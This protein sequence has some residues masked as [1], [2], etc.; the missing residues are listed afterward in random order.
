MPR[1]G[2]LNICCHI[3]APRRAGFAVRGSSATCIEP[4]S[5]DRGAA[6]AG[7]RTGS[8]RAAG[9]QCR[10]AHRANTVD[11]TRAVAS[12][13]G[14]RTVTIVAGNDIGV[15][16]SNIIGDQGTTLVA[17]SD[18]KIE[19]VTETRNTSGSNQISRSGVFSSDAAVT[20][21]KQEEQSSIR[22]SSTSAAGSTVGS[23]SGNV[24]IVAG[25][26][27]S[28]V[29]SD[30]IAAT[31]DVNILAKDVRITE[32][33]ETS[34]THTE[35]RYRQSGISVGVSSPLLDAGMAAR[36]LAE[37]SGKTESS[38]MQALGVAAGAGT[39]HNGKNA[40]EAANAR[41]ADAGSSSPM[42]GKLTVTAGGS[43]SE[44]TSDQSANTAKG[45]NVHAGGDVN[46]MALGGGADSNI[47]IQGSNVSAGKNVNLAADNKIELLAAE[48]T[49]SH[50]SSSSSSGWSAGVGFASGSQNGVTFEVGANTGKGSSDGSGTYWTNTHV[51][52]GN[53]V[54]MISG[55]DTTLKGAVVSADQVNAL[56]GGNLT[57]QS[58]QDTSVNAS[59]Q[60]GGGFSASVCTPPFCYG[61]SSASANA[62]NTHANGNY[63]SVTEQ[64]G[65]KAGDGGFNVHVAGDTNLIGGV[66]ESTQAAVDQAKNSF[67][68]A[69]LTIT[70]I[71]NVD[72][73]T[74]GGWSVS[75][76]TDGSK[77]NGSS[78]GFSNLDEGQESVTRS[79]ISGIAGD[80][81]VR[82]GD[83]S[84]V[85]ALANRWNEQQAMQ[86][87]AAQQQIT[88]AF[89]SS[90]ATAWGDYANKQEA[91]AQTDEDKAC[92][93]AS[94]ACR[95][96]GHMVIGGLS[97][98]VEGLLGAGAATQLAGTIDQAV[99]NAGLTGA[100]HD[101]VVAGLTTAV[102][103]AL[104]G[105]AG[106]A[107]AYNE[108]TNN[109]LSSKQ[110]LEMMDQLRE[111]ETQAER[112]KILKDY[113]DLSGRQSAEAK[114][115]TSQCDAIAEDAY[116]GKQALDSV[117][118]ELKNLAGD[119]SV[120]EQILGTQKNDSLFFTSLG[121][122]WI[123][124]H[125]NPIDISKQMRQ[126]GKD[127]ADSISSAAAY[128]S[129]GCATVVV[130]APAI[131]AFTAAGFW[132]GMAGSFIF[133]VNPAGAFVD[134]AIDK[135]IDTIRY[136][137]K[138][139]ALISTSIAEGIKGSKEMS[140]W[141]D[142]LSID[143]R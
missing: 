100:A 108:V 105:T 138:V 8:A 29:G 46:I 143:K 102:G 35:Q 89:G 104:G 78:A 3:F 40:Q 101:A 90:A 116:G 1:S 37:A 18:I 5:C 67:S 53:Q 69:N 64:S 23:I 54:N 122:G 103:G 99:T 137:L 112:D 33:R 71:A 9:A 119:S 128:A 91:A 107:G 109:Y 118:N 25:N 80:E 36:D 106:A 66:I 124:S 59:K 48:N 76:S 60:S 47:L 139:P 14:G 72:Q 73:Q 45:S 132:T 63:A 87:L 126:T 117:K 15:K 61:D 51:T 55:G 125:G 44:N 30:V 2:T 70:D 38:R 22:R 75:V 21:G 85:G 19:S 58:L 12:E 24:N 31:G 136:K 94:G 26:S 133:D 120:A 142:S 57:I 141:K 93:S 92:W 86:D 42:A 52:A 96:A 68:T 20:F 130:C 111:A 97:G 6:P 123:D 140:D 43:R 98:G 84:S 134:T 39:V 81:S 83:N 88:A 11:S 115:C 41:A 79:G 74:G 4:A 32:A 127:M 82:T 95:A 17:G 13:I 62:Y 65:I 110:V 77:P 10:R 56:V 131:P 49:V 28:Q 50:S 34:Q 121:N 135:S 27:Y 113:A 114:G 129:A 16:G 7:A